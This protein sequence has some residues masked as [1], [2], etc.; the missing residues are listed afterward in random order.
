MRIQWPQAQGQWLR[1]QGEALEP[2]RERSERAERLNPGF[3]HWAGA[4]GP[5][6]GR[7]PLP[8]TL[9]PEPVHLSVKDDWWWWRGEGQGVGLQLRQG[10]GAK[11]KGAV[12]EP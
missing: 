1:G 8:P 4:R 9:P 3:S 7:K 12:G 11:F 10:L 6:Q 2:G 5:A